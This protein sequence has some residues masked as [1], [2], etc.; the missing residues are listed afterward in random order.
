MPDNESTTKFR[1]DISELKKEFRE[2]QRTIQLVNSEFKA[3]T[4]GMGKW[5][6]SA[7]GLSAKVKQLNGVLEA[8]ETKLGSLEAQ[9]KLVAETE[10][11]LAQCGCRRYR[12]LGG[13][14]PDLRE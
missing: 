5:S 1:V 14:V 11:T 6:S 7:D 12:R 2:A 3:A 8:E 4:A 13:T 9:Y 10:G